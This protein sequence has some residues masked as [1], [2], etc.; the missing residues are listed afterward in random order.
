MFSKKQCLCHAP[1]G[2]AARCCSLKALGWACWSGSGTSLRFF[3]GPGV[4]LR[5]WLNTLDKFSVRCRRCNRKVRNGLKCNVCGAVVCS[6]NCFE[7]HVNSMHPSQGVDPAPLPLEY[8]TAP[9]KSKTLLT[10]CGCL[11]TLLVGAVCIGIIGQFVP[12]KPKIDGSTANEK[13]ISYEVLKKV[14]RGD[15][16]LVMELL[17]SE[18][19]SKQEVLKL[20]ESLQREYGG[21]YAY[22]DIFD[23][24][25]AWQRRP[26][27][28]YPEKEFRRHY[29]VQIA[30]VDMG[31]KDSQEIHWL[32]E[33]RDH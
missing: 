13:T 6:E 5:S 12:R 28:S 26:D 29:L 22:I 33:G 14:K 1:K 31:W 18:A 15:G 24:R 30:G 25:E 16:K 23:S 10:G 2:A 20:A 21:K 32:A 7:K 11:S 8:R 27:E 4:S 9:K 3:W 19:A 17:V